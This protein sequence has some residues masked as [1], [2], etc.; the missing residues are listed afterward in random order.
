MILNSFFFIADKS[1]RFSTYSFVYLGVW[2]SYLIFIRTRLL[3]GQEPQF[4][5]IIPIQIG[6]NDIKLIEPS[7]LLTGKVSVT[8]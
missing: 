4:F 1:F 7:N 5:S 2:S 6:T 8:I 3:L